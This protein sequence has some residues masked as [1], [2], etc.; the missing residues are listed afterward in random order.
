[1]YNPS[2]GLATKARAYKS[3]RQEGSLGGTSCTPRSAGE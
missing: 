1:M 2:F 3:A